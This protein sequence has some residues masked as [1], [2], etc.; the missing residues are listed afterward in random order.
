MNVVLDP[1]LLF[2][3]DDNWKDEQEKDNFVSKLL[4]F[5]DYIDK[6]DDIHIYWSDNME[7]LLWDCDIL[8][9]RQDKD[10]YNQSVVTISQKL[11]N[12]I[13]LLEQ[14]LTPAK[15]LPR[16]TFKFDNID[17]LHEFLSIIHT[18]IDLEQ[19]I[20]L[21]VS[22]SNDKEY[23]FTCDCHA[24]ELIPKLVRQTKDF[25]SIEETIRVYWNTLDSVSFVRLINLIHNNYYLTE[26]NFLYNF[27]A[28]NSFVKD[29]KRENRLDVQCHIVKQIIKKLTKTFR[30]S[31]DDPTLQDE[32]IDKIN[33]FRVSPQPTSRRIHYT[34]KTNVIKFTHY[35]PEGK[36]DVGLSHTRK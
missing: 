4:D 34:C 27:E 28:S 13:L 16:F 19:N 22:T 11:H 2:I 21:C 23:K 32:T 9:W 35:Y 29:V 6:N 26:Y 20:Y 18:I 8:P 24:Y 12:N 30:E 14:N 7:L 3:T 25:Y 17:I 33:R 5:L 31:Q 15:C 1:S 36:H 10:F